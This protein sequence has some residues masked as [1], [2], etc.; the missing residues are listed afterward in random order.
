MQITM[1]QVEIT[2]AIKAYVSSQININPG[3]NITVGFD[4]TSPL[5]AV[6]SISSDKTISDEVEDEIILIAAHGEPKA[7]KAPPKPRKA[8][9]TKKPELVVETPQEEV[10]AP[11]ESV[12]NPFTEA[13]EIQEAEIVE[14]A[15]A[16]PVEAAPAA[17]APVSIFNFSK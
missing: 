16:E 10:A 4:H 6:L 9:K 13:N 12:A 8:V 2:E 14:E 15:A 5:S 1:N 3:M 11:V 17:A 7:A